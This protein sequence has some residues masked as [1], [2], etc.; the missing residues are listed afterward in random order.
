[1]KLEIKNLSKKFE[2]KEV[3]NNINLE[4]ESGEVVSLVGR[5]GSGKTTLLKLITGI[6]QLDMGEITIDGVNI[7]QNNLKSNIIYIPDKFDYF[8]Y[9]KI[10]NII[11][12]YELAYENFDKDYFEKELVKNKIS[13]NKKI[14]ELSKGQTVI[15]GVILGLACRTNFLLLDEPLDGI[16]IINIKLII[17]YIIEAQDSGVGI[18]VSSHQLD[19]LENIS[20][21]IIYIDTTGKYGKEVD[22]MG[23]SKYQL[24]YEDKIPEEFANL[25]SVR[26][27]SNIGRVYIVLVRGSFEETRDLIQESAPLQCDE[28]PVLL[29]DIFIINNKGGAENDE[30]YFENHTNLFEE[31]FYCYNYFITRIYTFHNVDSI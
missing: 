13:L 1:M 10:K 7:E 9:T 28:L 16:D 21:K 23:Y 30:R 3:L 4:V 31:I 14:T 18:L 17:N 19:Y 25:D 26:I 29:E 15:F 24:V 5:N 22:K 6:Y 8:K 12:Y 20:D 27:V 2:K 11:K